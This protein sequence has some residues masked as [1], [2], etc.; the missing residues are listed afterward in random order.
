MHA[1]WFISLS[2]II[3]TGVKTFLLFTTGTRDLPQL[4]CLPFPPLS[5]S[6][7]SD[8]WWHITHHINRVSLC[9]FNRRKSVS[10]W[11]YWKS[12]RQNFYIPWC[13]LMIPYNPRIQCCIQVTYMSK[14]WWIKCRGDIY[15]ADFSIWA[16]IVQVILSL[17]NVFTGIYLFVS[18]AIIWDSVIIWMSVTVYP[19]HES[20]IFSVKQTLSS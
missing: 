10:F 1:T 9:Q 8:L 20:F 2:C 13:T 5:L 6:W 11:Q 19:I 7:L 4:G 14:F 16:K 18:P 12:Y 17:F 15:Y 3:G